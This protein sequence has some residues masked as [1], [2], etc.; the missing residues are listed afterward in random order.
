MNTFTVE[1]HVAVPLMNI[2]FRSAYT[3]QYDEHLIG[4]WSEWCGGPQMDNLAVGAMEA[5][6]AMNEKPKSTHKKP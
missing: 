6:L 1:T 5:R 3:H 2:P 4:S